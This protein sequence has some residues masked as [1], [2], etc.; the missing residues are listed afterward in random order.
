MFLPIVIIIS[1]LFAAALLTTSH[2]KNSNLALKDHIS[3]LTDTMEEKTDRFNQEMIVVQIELNRYK[4]QVKDLQQ[5]K[6]EMLASTISR[7][8]ERSEMI[9]KVMHEVGV[10]I[11]VT[12]DPQHSG[13]RY[14][15]I[16]DAPDEYISEALL[17]KTD[18]YLEAFN[19]IPISRP[20]TTMRITS[21]Y[22]SRI[23][24]FKK[25][26]AFHAGIDFGGRIG[27]NILATGNGVVKTSAIGKGYGKFVVIDHEHGYRTLYAHL[28]KKLVKRGDKISRGQIIGLLGNTGRSTGQHLHY[29]V[30]KNKKTVNPIKYLKAVDV[31]SAGKI[32]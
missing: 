21:K 32:D 24:P 29:E 28:S 7:L 31:I 4:E 5:E 25:T 11:E 27:D 16:A 1:F 3:V 18:R 19:S 12:E 22:G 13:G 15:S 10:V 6:T 26:K 20:L 14:I 30:H 2:H 23:D 17:L 8:N 9:K